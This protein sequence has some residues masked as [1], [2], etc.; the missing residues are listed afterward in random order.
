MKN[1]TD[2]VSVGVKEQLVQAVRNQWE[3]ARAVLWALLGLVVGLG[4]MM[5]EISP[6][7]AALCAAV[8]LKNLVPA[9]LGSAVGSLLL[10]GLVGGNFTIKYAA[11]ILLIAVV[12]RMGREQLQR[13]SDYRPL[14]SAALAFLGLLLPTAAMLLAQPFSVYKLVLALAEATVAGACAYFLDRSLRAFSLGQGLF[15]LTRA[16]FISVVLTACIVVVSLSNITFGGISFGRLLAAALVLLCALLGGERWGAIAGIVC[17]TAVSLALFPKVQ[18]L[19]ISALAGLAAGVFSSLGKFGCAG[20]YAMTF[21][22]MCVITA[23]AP[24]LPLLY[25]TLIC[26]VGLM[27]LPDRALGAL[28]AKVL[29]QPED[30]S[31]K[32]VRQLIL[33]RLGEASQALREIA[34][35]T[36]AVSQRL[37]KAR[38]GSLEQVYDNAVDAVCLKCGLKTRCWQQE[39]SDTANVFNHLTPVLRQ[40]GSVCEEDFIYPLSARCTRRAQLAQQVNAGYQELTRK[41][42]MSRKVARVRSVVTDQFE[43]LGELLEGLSRELCSIGGYEERTAVRV[44]EYLEQER[45]PARHSDCYRDREGRIFVRIDLAPYRVA[46]L[47][48]ARMAKELSQVCGCDFD[49]PQKTERTEP[50]AAGEQERLI[51]L[52]FREKAAYQAEY[53]CS[54][55]ICQGCRLC[56]DA[57]QGFT[58]QRSVA[59]IVLSDGMGSGTAAAVDSNMTVSL[60]VKLIE[61]GVDYTAALKIVNSALLVKSGEESLS[62]VDI[63]AVNLYTGQAHFYKA[64][65]APTFIRRGS[66]TGMVESTSLPAGI[67]TAVE[68]EKSSV[69]LRDGDLIVMV[70]DGATACGSEW[71]GAVIDHFAPDGDLQALCDDIA[72]TARLRRNDNHDDDITVAACRIQKSEIGIA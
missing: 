37:D 59:H 8:P 14:V 56:G 30:L 47:D 48:L 32:S 24:V 58:D 12:R 68:F 15:T 35:T 54:Q 67:L 62:T 26:T 6:F 19:G 72:S 34:R 21:G 52:S 22:A 71:I 49:L 13:W 5:L 66:R 42:G 38:A 9:A 3:A 7:G 1:R 25:E 27:L 40:N 20:A 28:R 63:A 2:F 53:A 44:Q 41:E 69:Q 57:W 64:G 23:P 16:D 45:C 50:N 4:N 55:H 33:E 10:S 11:A 65:A 70:S 17:G 60:I 31:G 39:Y 46:R 18:L 43:G 29:R 36:Q 51:R 61:A